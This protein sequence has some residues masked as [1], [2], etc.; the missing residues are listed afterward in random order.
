MGEVTIVGP[1]D[2][3]TA[4][5]AD[6][7]LAG[8]AVRVWGRNAN[9][10]AALSERPI[11]LRAS[12]FN[13]RA[14]PALATTD[15]Q[16]AVR[17]AEVVFS[18]VPGYSHREVAALLAKVLR[19]GQIAVFSPGS[20][21]SFELVRALHRIGKIGVFVAEFAILPYGARRSD[22]NLV[23]VVTTA[24]RIPTGVF[25]AH[26]TAE[27]V[28][29]LRPYFKH[30][31]PASTLLDVGLLNPSVVIH[32][33]LLATNIAA[34]EQIDASEIHTRGTATPTM[35]LAKTLDVERIAIRDALGYGP[36][37][38][39]QA[40]YLDHARRREGFWG[41]ISQELIDQSGLWKGKLSLDHRYV[42]EDIAQGLSLQVSLGES[43]E[44]SVRASRA[45]LDLT[46][47]VSGVDFSS[48]RTLAGLGLES[49]DRDALNCLLRD[50]W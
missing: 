33:S 8:H 46:E 14:R 44:V 21:G 48:R 18:T 4:M 25:P 28:D 39:E 19:P 36:P 11:E 34:I 37:H 5:A 35:R 17:G 26:R 1:G 7:A 24:T 47:V 13:G 10:I 20:F 16:Q 29:R 32:S 12:G 43:L 15:I 23:W 30:V 41:E 22:P 31:C 45:V 42:T 6:L 2:G 38:Y 3:G 49:Y 50:G 40:A 27:V 9:V